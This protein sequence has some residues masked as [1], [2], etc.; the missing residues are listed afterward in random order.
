MNICSRWPIIRYLPPWHRIVTILYRVLKLKCNHNCNSICKLWWHQYTSN[1]TKELDFRFSRRHI[2]IWLA[3]LLFRR[4]VWSTD[5]LEVLAA[6]IIRALMR[7][8]KSSYSRPWE[9]EIS[10]RTP[11]VYFHLTKLPF[12]QLSDAFCLERN[13]PLCNSGAMKNVVSITLTCLFHGG[14]LAKLFMN[15]NQFEQLCFFSISSEYGMLCSLSHLI[16]SLILL[17]EWGLYLFAHYDTL[18]CRSVLPSLAADSE[19]TSDTDIYIIQWIHL[20][21]IISTVLARFPY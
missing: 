20:I 2:W 1:N 5:I 17:F 9:H 18:H 10:T 6:S 7:I 21:T 19:L 12:T 8:H 13:V 14:L 15:L 4:V 16:V 3:S 11:L